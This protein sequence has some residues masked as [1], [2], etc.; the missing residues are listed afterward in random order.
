MGM[1]RAAG[2]LTST[3]LS[4][5]AVREPHGV[6]A[7]R[8]VLAPHLFPFNPS[9]YSTSPPD[10]TARTS[11]PTKLPG[12]GEV[13]HW[14]EGET[15]RI[16]WDSY[17]TPYPYFG[18]VYSF[19]LCQ[20]RKASGRGMRPIIKCSNCPQRL[21]LRRPTVLKSGRPSGKRYLHFSVV[22]I[23]TPQI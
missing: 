10:S 18:L 9:D 17:F 11:E 22:I 7:E 23:N 19:K 5:C 8:A 4:G 21:T 14:A 20:P 1:R 12:P 3:S 2:C 15:G 13:V 6:C 16:H